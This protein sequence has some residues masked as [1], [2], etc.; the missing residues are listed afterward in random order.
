MHP[1]TLFWIAIGLA[2]GALLG[3]FDPKPRRCKW[4]PR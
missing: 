1:S 3:L 4:E 2:L